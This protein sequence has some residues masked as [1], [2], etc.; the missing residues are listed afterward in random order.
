MTQGYI[1]I[2]RLG[3]EVQHFK[4]IN[5]QCPEKKKELSFSLLSF[6]FL[7]MTVSLR[8]IYLPHTKAAFW[9]QSSN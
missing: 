7:N 9:R 1:K 3:A 8:I 2:Q 6:F 4:K 5:S